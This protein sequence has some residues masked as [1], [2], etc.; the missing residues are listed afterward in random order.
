[1]IDESDMVERAERRMWMRRSRCLRVLKC[2]PSQSPSFPDVGILKFF[3]TLVNMGVQLPELQFTSLEDIPERTS[4]ARKA[5]LEHRT[6]DVE[7]RL[8]QL[9]KFY[10]A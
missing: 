1:M 10:W 5:F 6:R 7:F 9:R 8:V 2:R 4:T 3:K